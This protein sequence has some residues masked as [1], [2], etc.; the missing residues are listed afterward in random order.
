MVATAVACLLALASG[1]ALAVGP[2]D[3]KQMDTS[4]F[5]THWSVTGVELAQTFT[6]GQTGKLDAVMVNANGFGNSAD[7]SIQAGGIL[8][9]QTVALNSSG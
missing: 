4:G 3:Q 1:S 9:E 8:D 2:V 6:A 7:F 5:A